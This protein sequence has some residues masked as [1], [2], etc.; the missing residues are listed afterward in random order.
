MTDGA[1]GRQRASLPALLYRALGCVAL[2]LAIAGVILPG[3]PA[4]PFLLL[5]VWAL[6]RGA[7]ELARRVETHPRFEP[8][9]RNWR[10]RRVVPPRAK[11]LAVAS[12][13][14]SFALLWLSGPGTPVLVLVGAILVCVGAY[15]VSR[16]SR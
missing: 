16:P 2:A 14:L 1:K 13:A 5:A 12:M 8:T 11:A 3:L 9:L 15:L 6:R 4:T 7:P 10:E